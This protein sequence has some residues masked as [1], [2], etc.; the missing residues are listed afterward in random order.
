MQ[1]EH[2]RIRHGLVHREHARSAGCCIRSIPTA[3]PADLAAGPPRSW[4]PGVVPA[5]LGLGDRRLGAAAGELLRHRGRE[6]DLRPGEPLRPRRLRL[7]AGLHLGVRQHRRRCRARCWRSSSGHDPLDATT[8]RMPAL[9]MT[10]P[11]PRPISRASRSDCRANT[12]PPTSM[13]ACGPDS[14]ARSQPSR[15]RARRCVT[16]SLPHSRYAVPTYYIVAPAE[17]A[18]NLARFDGVRYGPRRLT[19]GADVAARSIAPRGRGIRPRGAPPHPGRHLRAERRLLRRLLRQ[20]TGGAG[21]ASPTTFAKVFAAGVDFL[22]TPTTPTPAFRAGEKTD[23]PVSMY[24]A[25]IF[26]CAGQPGGP[27]RR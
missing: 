12:S 2:G 13:P 1:D 21:A 7:L 4:P 20:G 14:T 25:D 24:L 23:D 5:A 6:A 10:L 26:V 22:L 8:S 27:A 19:G 9:P 17:A 18:S 11:A 16:V 3:C 15:A